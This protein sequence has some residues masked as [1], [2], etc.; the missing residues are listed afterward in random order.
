MIDRQRLVS[1]GITTAAVATVA[2][3]LWLKPWTTQNIANEPT[4]E[5][6][7][8]ITQ[9]LHKGRQVDIVFAVDTTGSMGGLLDG[10]KRTVWSIANQVRDLEKDANLRV[11]LVAYRDTG[12]AYVTKD[13]AL[14]DDL[15]AVFAELSSYQAAGGGDVPENVDAALYDA[16]H[17]MKWRGA[18]KKMIFLVGDAP[19]SSRGEVPRFDVTAQQAAHMQIKVNTIRCGQDGETANAWQQIASLGDGAFSTIQQDG[20]VQQLAT[21]YD[22]K[23]AALAADIDSNTVIY[24]DGESRRRWE[25]KMAVTTAAPASARADRGAYFAKGGGVAAAANEDVVGGIESGAMS[26]DS[27]DTAKLPEPMRAKPKAELEADLKDR[28]AKRQAAQKEIA[29]LTKKRDE[30]IKANKK[31]DSGFDSVVKATIEAQLK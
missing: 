30:Y 14:T 4:G 21:P 2:L 27:I 31:D 9:T 3:V 29:E 22:D 10:A 20:G 24:G 5:P 7:P 26:I 18:S 12:D 13:F 19:P 11:G 15:D 23:M 16:V 1:T 25:G 17:K 6:D 8:V 28:A